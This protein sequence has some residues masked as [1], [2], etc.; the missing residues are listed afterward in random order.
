MHKK[1]GIINLIL[2][3]IAFIILH[4]AI[5]IC[6]A[7]VFTLFRENNKD[8]L[9]TVSYKEKIE[10]LENT[11]AEYER[12]YEN[13]KIYD[14]STFI[15]SKIA[16]RDIYDFY[17]VLVIATDHPVEKGSAVINE[18]GLVGIIS[19]ANKTTAKVSLLTG[20]KIDI[21]VKIGESY[22]L[23]DT[24]DKKEKVLI[25]HNINNYTDIKEGEEVTTSGLQEVDGGLKIGTV[26]KTEVAGVERII[27]VEPSVD[28]DALNY[29]MVL[30]K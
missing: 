27:Y 19:E 18:R 3:M 24:Y 9:E 6:L 28:F 30:N 13:L 23:L 25:V 15:L 12:A 17:D 2:V 29:L 1:R 8:V 14:S 5:L 11:L 7:N 20:K 10:S 16:L 21:S 4:N 26:K 22:G